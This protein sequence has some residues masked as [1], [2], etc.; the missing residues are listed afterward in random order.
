[1]KKNIYLRLAMAT[2]VVAVSIISISC[3]KSDNS[4]SSGNTESKTVSSSSQNKASANRVNAW[5]KAVDDY[6]YSKVVSLFD[7]LTAD[8]IEFLTTEK[9]YDREAFSYDLNNTGDGVVIKGFN[10]SSEMYPTVIVPKFIE[11]YPVVE[12]KGFTRSGRPSLLTVVLPNTIK[13]IETYS[14]PLF[15]LYLHK[16]NMPTSLEKIGD[17]VFAQ[18]QLEGKIILPDSL[19]E[20]GK[21]AFSDC[22]NITSVKFGNKIQIIT[23][24]SFSDCSNLTEV[25]FSNSIKQIQYS[26]FSKTG[27]ENLVL[28]T[29]L[30]I[31]GGDAFRG[32]ISLKT[33]AFPN[34][35][36]I[37]EGHSFLGC[38]SLTDV[39]IPND[40]TSLQWKSDQVF[41]GCGNMKLAS[42][43]KLQDL[44]YKGDF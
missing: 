13:T 26:A 7:S 31:L 11:D 22:T 2:I 30:E 12:I 36:K 17:S 43:K 37:I 35:L 41:A 5:L 16:I 24:Y 32:S 20:F 4:S 15:S 9:A 23:T 39:T 10:G 27:L 3:K 18:T 33:V 38:L 34:S 25:Q 21:T 19:V 29:N 6:D 42:R 40:L 14:H 28:P 1:M 8:D 44:G